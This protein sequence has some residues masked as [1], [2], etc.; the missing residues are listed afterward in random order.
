M[1]WLQRKRIRQAIVFG[2]SDAKKN[3]LESGRSR[4]KEYFAF[5]SLFK[6]YYVFSNQYTKKKLWA[7]PKSERESVAEELGKLNRQHDAWV[8]DMYQNRKF[9]A[10]W[11]QLKWETS[12]KRTKKR[13]LAYTKQFKTGKGL[14]VQRNVDIHR[15]HYLFGTIKIGNNVLLAKNVF[16][17]F[18]GFLEIEDNVSLSDG[19]V[20]E[21]HSHV[22]SGFALA[23]EGKLAQTHLVIE[24]GVSVGSKAL[25]ME[26]CSRI[27]R[28]ARIGAGAVVRSNVPPYA[29]AIGNPAKVVGFVMTPEEVEKKEMEYPEEKRISPEKFMAYY[30]KYFRERTHETKK[31]MK[32]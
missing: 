3:A 27:G 6:T 29:I 14:K 15:E 22:S 31:F 28:H 23:G 2:W 30:N 10:K 17:D 24:Q 5:L 12:P 16:I 18:S 25:I 20:I 7:L 8:I 11:S 9:I 19:V 4:L 1:N 32:L 13:K 21:T 26:T